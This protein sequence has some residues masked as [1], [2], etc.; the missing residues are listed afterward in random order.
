MRAVM[1]V[2]GSNLAAVSVSQAGP[3]VFRTGTTGGPRQLVWVDRSGDVVGTLG[4]ADDA[5]P[6]NADLSSDDTNV[7]LQRTINGNTDI[8]IQDARG[9]LSHVSVDPAEEIGPI[10]SP[11]GSSIVFS[12]RSGVSFDL[13]EM[14]ASGAGEPMLLLETGLNNSAT[15]WHPDGDVILYRSPDAETG[16]DVWALPLATGEDAFPVVQSS[17]D[18]RDGQFSPDG[19]W[20]AYQS[21]NSGRFEVYLRPFPGPGGTST[22]STNG[23]AQVRW[24]ADGRELF[25]VGLDGQLMAVSIRLDVAGQRVDAA[26]PVPLFQTRIGGAVQGILRQQYMVAG[27]GARFLM[28]RLTEEAAMSPITLMLNWAP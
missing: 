13:Y 1:L 10:W 14:S 9:S 11:D 16:W 4:D 20:I 25:Y 15:D 6:V 27:D 12:K 3:I 22:I 8:W 7:V 2:N 23:G 28:H 18:E 26:A 21:N 19:I 5:S 24:R 17:F